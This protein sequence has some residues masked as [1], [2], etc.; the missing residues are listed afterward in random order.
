MNVPCG[1]NA[2]C[3]Q[4]DFQLQLTARSRARAPAR[5]RARAWQV[6]SY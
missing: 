3:A 6:I 2:K 1:Y 4:A 5:G